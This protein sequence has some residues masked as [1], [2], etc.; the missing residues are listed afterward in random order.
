VPSTR[1]PNKVR[2]K[3]RIAEKRLIYPIEVLI[4][5]L[6]EILIG[7]LIEALFDITLFQRQILEHKRASGLKCSHES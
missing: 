1:R 7:A 5:V 2:I 4:E 3:V 6:I